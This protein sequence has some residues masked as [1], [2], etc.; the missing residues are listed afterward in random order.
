MQA[1]LGHLVL[2]ARTG[3]FV[4]G[5]AIDMELVGL[6]HTELRWLCAIAGPAMLN[7]HPEP[8]PPAPRFKKDPGRP[9][10]LVVPEP[11]PGQE[12]LDL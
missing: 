8:P 12:E 6:S 11:I 7:A 5:K 2:E 9:F 1:S 4:L 10:D 3:D